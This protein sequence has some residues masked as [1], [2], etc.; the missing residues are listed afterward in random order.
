MLGTPNEKTGQLSGLLVSNLDHPLVLL[1]RFGLQ[2]IKRQRQARLI[3][4]R[5]IFMQHVLGNRLINRR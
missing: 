4:I 1:G 5:C 3:T 2:S